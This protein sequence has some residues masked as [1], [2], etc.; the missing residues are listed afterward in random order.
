MAVDSGFLLELWI[1]YSIGALWLLLRLSVRIR[2][3]GI[4]ALH[5]DDMFSVLVLGSWTVN[6]VNIHIVHCM[7]TSIALIPSDDPDIMASRIERAEYGRKVNFSTWHTYILQLWCLKG[8]VLVFYRRLAINRWQE[9][10]LKVT[11]WFCAITFIILMGIL[12]FSCIPYQ[13]NWRVWP[14]P[15]SWCKSKQKLLIVTS[16]FNA[17]TDIL[18]LTIPIPLIWKLSLPPLK[19]AGVVILLSS[20]VFVLIAWFVLCRCTN[21]N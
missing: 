13:N 15:V 17:S 4:L 3:I 21:S 12:T 10:L 19:R 11:S 5:L 20:G 2:T 18:L 6:C 1:L 8:T 14:P 9:T 16:C 7:G